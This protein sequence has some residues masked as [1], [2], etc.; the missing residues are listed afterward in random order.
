MFQETL[1]MFISVL[2]RSGKHIIR[3]LGIDIVSKL[4]TMPPD[5]IP[6]N[7]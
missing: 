1:Q 6:S 5:K 3:E 7:F 4:M 2:R